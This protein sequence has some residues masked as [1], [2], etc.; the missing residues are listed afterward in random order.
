MVDEGGPSRSSPEGSG[1]GTKL[2]AGRKSLRLKTADY[3]G[4]HCKLF[5]SEQLK[6]SKGGL[7]S[8]SPDREGRGGHSSR[9]VEKVTIK[10]EK[11]ILSEVRERFPE[12][13][14]LSDSDL[15]RIALRKMVE[16]RA[17][18]K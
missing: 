3:R 5:Y 4:S 17:S 10:V 15:V 16:A 9:K 11:E 2:S 1:E 12:Y 6:I 7:V 13:K 14:D 8:G 18:S